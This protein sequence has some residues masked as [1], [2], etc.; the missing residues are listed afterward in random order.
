LV[1]IV[2]IG[3]MT[4]W[5]GIS[6]RI[7]ASVRRKKDYIVFIAFIS[8]YGAFLFLTIFFIITRVILTKYA[9]WKN[10]N[11]SFNSTHLP[12]AWEKTAS[13]RLRSNSTGNKYTFDNT[14]HRSFA[15]SADIVAFF[16]T[17]VRSINSASDVLK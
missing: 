2:F 17:I 3:V 8:F 6:T 5:H 1:S 4:F 9:F 11:I 10:M 13:S 7:N 16:F 12:T 14:S 15:I